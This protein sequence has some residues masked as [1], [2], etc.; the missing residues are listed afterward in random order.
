MDHFDTIFCA[1]V[2]QK[3]ENEQTEAVYGLPAKICV[4]AGYPLIDE[5]REKYAESEHKVNTRKKI[6]IA[7]SWQKENIIDS[8]LEQLLD[9]LKQTDCEIIVRPHPQEVRLKKEYMESLKQKYEPDGIEIQTDFSSNNPV[10]EADLLITDWSDISWEYAFTTLRPVMYINTP[11]KV[12]NPEWQKIEYPPLNIFLRD[13]LGKS[14][15]VDQ[16]DK[17]AE[18]AQYLL[19][20]TDAYR[21]K[22]NALAYEYIY[23]LGSSS[24]A[25]AKYIIKAVQNKIKMKGN[26]KNEK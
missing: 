21:E 6:L 26:K 23:N 10:M 18:T 5:M 4:E 13:Q 25:G 7:P 8:C 15:D 24:E 11:M 1:G 22:I 16:L 17:A 14:L 3:I 2:H 9:A 12:M 20:N 19:E